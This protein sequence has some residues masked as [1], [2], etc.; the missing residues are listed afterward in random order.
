MEAPEERGSDYEALVDAA[1]ALY[2]QHGIQAV[3][4]DAVRAAAGV[5]LKRLYRT[6]RSKDDLVEATLRE[7]DA[8][9]RTAI[10]TYIDERRP[11]SPEDA[12]LA[13]FDWM[14][15]WF[16]EESFRGCAFINAFGERGE[17]SPQVAAAVRDHK[18]AFRSALAEL[19]AAL[20]LPPGRA[21]ALTE[22]LYIV[23]NGAMATAPITGSPQTARDARDIARTL[24]D[25]AGPA[26]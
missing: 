9:V 24:V 14:A 22:R 18:R 6:F 1:G 11:V 8:A 2:Y 17:D 7:R 23:A 26:R 4:M 5:P 13:L 12:V 16:E 19:V 25:A 21:E 3:G 15:S 10:R 20:G